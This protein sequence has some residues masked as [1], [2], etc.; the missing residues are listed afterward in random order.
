MSHGVEEGDDSVMH[1]EDE[2]PAVVIAPAPAEAAVV[3]E[4]KV[5][6]APAAVIAP[7]V[8]IAPAPAEAAVV[9]EVVPRYP[10]PQEVVTALARV[11]ETIHAVDTF[12]AQIDQ[13]P[14]PEERM[15]VSVYLDP[16]FL[17]R[18]HRGSTL[19]SATARR[20]LEKMFLDAI[21]AELA[22][23]GGDGGAGGGVNGGGNGDDGG[24]GGGVGG[25][26]SNNG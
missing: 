10:A 21:E 8:V 1:Y 9:E 20:E 19:E 16:A 22:K 18:L 7:A 13:V 11:N 4:A 23:Q 17:N 6:E 5:E 2:A 14:A 26:V 12:L 24:A 15:F 25:A 3:E